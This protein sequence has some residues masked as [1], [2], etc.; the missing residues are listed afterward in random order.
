M[1]GRGLAVALEIIVGIGT[2]V[3]KNSLPIQ[4]T[5]NIFYLI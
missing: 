4:F 1:V 2:F 5:K 3:A